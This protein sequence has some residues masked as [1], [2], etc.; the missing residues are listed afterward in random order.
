MLKNN[1]C[2][3]SFSVDHIGRAKMFYGEKL[4]IKFDEAGEDAI[5]LYTAG[6]SRIRVYQKSDHQPATSTV[7]NFR[8]DNIDLKVS[9][10][11]CGRVNFEHYDGELSTNEKGIHERNGSK[12]AWFKDPAGNILSLVQM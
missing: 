3:F 9:E 2:F 5:D 11:A 6:G 12:I 8:V 1:A 10:M 4:G 7:L